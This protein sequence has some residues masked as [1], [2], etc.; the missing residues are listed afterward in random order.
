MVTR[1]RQ[2]IKKKTRVMDF[3]VFNGCLFCWY[4]WPSLFKHSFH[5]IVL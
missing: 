1:F 4:C 5:D 2:K 3:F